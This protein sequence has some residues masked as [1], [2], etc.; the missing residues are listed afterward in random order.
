VRTS[1]RTNLP[2]AVFTMFVWVFG[3]AILRV[4]LVATAKGSTS[5]YGPL[6]TPIAVLLWMYILSIAVLI[7]AALNAAVDQVWPDL[8]QKYSRAGRQVAT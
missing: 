5:I 3:S 6:A 8:D 2:G 7:G 4:V 1:W